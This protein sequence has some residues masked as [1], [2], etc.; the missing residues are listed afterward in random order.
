MFSCEYSEIFKNS[1]FLE[2]RWLLLLSFLNPRNV[3]WEKILYP[4]F[5]ERLF[6]SLCV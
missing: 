5:L 2:H 6:N 1:F 3:Y 4:K